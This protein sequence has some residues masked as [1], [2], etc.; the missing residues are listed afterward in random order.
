MHIGSFNQPFLPITLALL[1]QTWAGLRRVSNEL[2]SSGPR[3]KGL[4]LKS[5]A[6]LNVVR[7]GGDTDWS[8]KSS[9]LE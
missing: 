3:A 4:T 7:S 9:K 2:S 6:S 5:E 8:I 1:R